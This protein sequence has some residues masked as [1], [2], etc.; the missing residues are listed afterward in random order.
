MSEK[1]SYR[2]YVNCF[3]S[4]VRDQFILATEMEEMA[5]SFKRLGLDSAAEELNGKAVKIREQLMDMRE[6]FNQLEMDIPNHLKEI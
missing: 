4:S 2:E 6:A 1:I 3:Y 5:N